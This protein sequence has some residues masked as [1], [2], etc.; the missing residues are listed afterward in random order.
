[1]IKK[2]INGDM[3]II[4]FL[5]KEDFSTIALT[6]LKTG[7]VTWFKITIK[8]LSLEILGIH[9]K[10]ARITNAISIT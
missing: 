10:T 9:D 5:P 4:E 1:M 8:G 7:S 3:S 2:T 6:G